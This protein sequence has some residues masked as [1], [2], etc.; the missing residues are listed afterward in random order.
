MRHCIILFTLVL[1]SLKAAAQKNTA[2]GIVM[3]NVLDADDSKPLAGTTITLRRMGDSTLSKSFI[4][5]TDGAFEIDR[6]PFGHYTIRF[7][8]MGYASLQ[9]D[10]IY[11]RDDRFD[12]NLGDIKLSKASNPLDNVI[13]YAEKPLIENKDGKISYN[14]GESALSAGSNTAELLKNMP[15]VSNDPNGKIL[16]KG[17][18][19]RILIDDKPVD[20]NAQQLADLLE[21]LPG[22]SI[23]KIEL[24][25]NPPPQYATEQG[26]VINIV[27]KKGKVGWVGKVSLSVG[28]RGEGMVNGNGSYRG[29][30]VNI[31]IAAGTG[32]SIIKGSS[33]SRRENVYKDSSNYFNTDG[34]WENRSLR[35]NFRFQLDYDADK[36]NQWGVVLQ[37]NSSHFDNESNTQ[38][39][40]LN[41]N[42]ELYRLSR[43]NN[44]SNGDNYSI[45]PQF[46]YTHKGKNPAQVLR[47]IGG[48]SYGKTNNDRLFFQEFLKPDGSPTGTDSTQQQETNNLTHNIS[49]RV[50]YDVP[51]KLKGW[52]FSTGASG[53]TTN[54]HNI[55]NTFYLKKPENTLTPSPALS[56][57]FT[58]AQQIYTV[59]AGV[60]A[61]L[62]PSWRAVVNLQLEETR[63]NF[64]FKNG[65]NGTTN[66][67]RN[68]LPAVTLRKE[69]SRQFNLAWVYRQSIRRPGIN[70]LNPAIDYGDPY[71]LRFGNPSL[72]P[73]TAHNFDFNINWSKGKS[74]IN[75]SLGY[76]KVQDII[77]SIR[78]LQTDGKTNTTYQNIASRNEYEAGVWGGYTFSKKLRMNWSAGY[79]FN[80]YGKREKELF[81][82]RDGSSL[83]ASLN[84]NILLSPLFTLDG[85]FRFSSFADP[86]G[87]ARSNVNM[88]LGAQYKFFSKR[89]I[90]A[91]N[92]ID[93]LR[94]QRLTT[95]TYG[96][97]FNLESFN[98]TRTRNFRIAL[99][100]QLN[101]VAVSKPAGKKINA[102]QLK[103]LIKK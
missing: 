69:F 83:Y 93:P 48:Y 23:E 81:K 75:G 91:F 88:N 96:S 87:R 17:K 85:N 97:N 29:N 33:Y 9:M 16:L 58:F 94:T 47:I 19:P 49:L 89:L 5:G 86:Q 102:S 26:G 57:D 15:L 4:T 95:Y 55:L 14:V 82:Y 28:T 36:R 18:E 72:N 103:Q 79:S 80:Q 6:L 39:G 22:S 66:D 52:T 70:E 65:S 78:T 98:S 92:A 59:R 1:F 44:T 13:V 68:L 64:N 7:T 101:K 56:S 73:S 42:K 34:A 99:T 63:F 24:L 40:N 3:G 62:S 32:A 45:N 61:T 12:F 35:P 31:S 11:L 25:Q 41:R 10:S 27:T 51:L 20:L 67:Y 46:S 30:K 60:T 74:Y 77:N 8:Q 71:N 53:A 50:N 84:Y 90:V 76:N 21:S 2:V 43:R 100:W 54:N 37:G 38:Y